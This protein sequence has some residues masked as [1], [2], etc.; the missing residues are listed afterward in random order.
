M[1]KGL[2]SQL[3]TSVITTLGLVAK[4]ADAAEIDGNHHRK[5]HRPDQ[6]GNHEVDRGNLEPRQHPHGIGCNPPEPE[7]AEDPQQH[8]Q[9]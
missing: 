8:P 9:R 4:L 6:H 5:D 3:I 7:A 1:V 2:I